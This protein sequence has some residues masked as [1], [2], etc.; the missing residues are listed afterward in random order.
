[1]GPLKVNFGDSQSVN[2]LRLSSGHSFRQR[3]GQIFGET[4]AILDQM[5]KQPEVCSPMVCLNKM[6]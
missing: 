6:D 3:M 1:M 4:M 2:G 5:E